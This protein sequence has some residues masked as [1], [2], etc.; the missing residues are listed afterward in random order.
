M[1]ENN[2]KES[3]ESIFAY[4]DGT[5]FENRAIREVFSTIYQ[6]QAWNID[7]NESVSG[8]G[9]GLSQTLELRRQIPRL[10]EKFSVKS[11]LD[12]PCGDF[13]WLR[14]ID[15]SRLQYTGADIVPQLVEHNNRLYASGGRRFI[16]LDLTS[17]LLP[18][19][20][21]ILCRDC[22]VHFSYNDLK[23]ALDN[24]MRSECRYLLTTTF[25]QQVKN[26]DCVTGGWR[27]LNLQLA[28]FYFPEPLDIIDEKCTEANGLFSDKSLALWKIEDLPPLEYE[29][30]IESKNT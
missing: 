27:P 8:P 19:N 12:V 30:G 14:Q 10:L 6:E 17:Q 2:V 15:F 25:M 29:N 4:A 9:S 28:P 16:L 13:Y 22:L 23:K 1:S 7:D 3:R 21:L 11:I 20:D 18:H 24:I 5:R 26:H